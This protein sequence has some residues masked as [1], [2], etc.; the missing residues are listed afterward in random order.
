[1]TS[2]TKA[3]QVFFSVIL[4]LIIGVKL[5]KLSQECKINNNLYTKG[6]LILIN[7]QDLPRPLCVIFSL[8]NN[9]IKLMTIID[10]TYLV[11]PL[12]KTMIKQLEKVINKLSELSEAQLE[13]IAQMIMISIESKEQLANGSDTLKKMTGSI[14]DTTLLSESLLAKDWLTEEEDNAWQ[15]L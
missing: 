4:W 3:N 15:N 8:T 5:A 10:E 7:F 14:S 2:G 6:N 11:F 13:E 1:M 9:A 12:S